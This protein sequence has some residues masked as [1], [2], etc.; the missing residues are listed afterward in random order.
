MVQDEFERICD[1]EKR[2]RHLK[3]NLWWVSVGIRE[4]WDVAAVLNWTAWE[5]MLD[6]DMQGRTPGD[7]M[8]SPAIT[9]TGAERDWLM[10]PPQLPGTYRMRPPPNAD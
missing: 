1:N 5:Q 10:V 3:K 7:V 9:A 8:I 6:I 4:R 2:W